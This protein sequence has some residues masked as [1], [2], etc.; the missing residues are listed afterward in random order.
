MAKRILFVCSGNIHR[1]PTAANM[2]RD[3]K[4]FEFRSAGTS[5]GTPTPVSAELVDWADKIFA[6]ASERPLSDI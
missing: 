3:R 2:F 4:G 6:R 1:S 5:I